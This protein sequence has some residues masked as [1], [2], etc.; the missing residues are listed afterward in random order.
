MANFFNDT[1]QLAHYLDHP[2]VERTA[3]LKERDFTEIANFDF[4]PVDTAD[5]IDS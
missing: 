3:Q 1:P 4:A 5:A 2:L